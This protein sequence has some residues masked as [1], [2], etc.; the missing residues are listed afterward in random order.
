V[1]S[2]CVISHDLTLANACRLILDQLI[3][4]SFEMLQE[5][6]E[7]AQ[8]YIWDAESVPA[9]PEAMRNAQGS[10]KLAIVPKQLQA[11]LR[12]SL[13]ADEFSFVQGPWT[14]LS[15]Q[16]FLS[17]IASRSELTVSDSSSSSLRLGRDRILQKLLESNARVQEDE[18]K[19]T[20]FLMRAVHDI[21]VP[22]MTGQGY[23]GLLLAGQLGSLT[24]EQ[25]RVLERMKRSLA[26]LSGLTDSLM[27]FGSDGQFSRQTP[28]A[29]KAQR[30]ASCVEACVSQAVHEILPL[31]EQKGITLTLDVQPP[32][33]P[34][35]FDGGQIEQVLVNLIDNACKFTPRHGAIEVRGY[36]T[37]VD[38]SGGG[39][40]RYRV[41][42][43]DTGPGVA[44]EL[45]EKIF[46]EYAS[47]QES[48]GRSGAGLGLAICRML[49]NAHQ[50]RIWATSNGRGAT[51]SFVL[52]YAAGHSQRSDDRIS[53]QNNYIARAV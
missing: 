42:I 36:N 21:R 48:A 47:Y 52:P 45:T 10:V 26:R 3:P 32:A 5:T 9:M 14:M 27:D 34:I 13:P 12:A 16:V 17:S 51:F 37:E 18:Q 39:S 33:H 11:A 49:I 50:G 31:V 40:A 29:R 22:L 2:I 46:D 28:L 44:A 23:L 15:L 6:C 30:K 41:D 53:P 4:E 8:V 20:N 19:R 7:G 1:I 35:H 25:I 43:S 24:E 38:G